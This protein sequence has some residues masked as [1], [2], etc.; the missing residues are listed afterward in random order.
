[1]L[2][3]P[4]L[5]RKCS[6]AFQRLHF[7]PSYNH[8]RFYMD[9]SVVL[10][11]NLTLSTFQHSTF[12]NLWISLEYRASEEGGETHLWLLCSRHDRLSSDRSCS[13]TERSASPHWGTTRLCMFVRWLRNQWRHLRAPGR[14]RNERG[15]TSEAKVKYSRIACCSLRRN[16]WEDSLIGLSFQRLRLVAPHYPRRP[17]Q[18][19]I[20]VRKTRE[21]WP[22]NIS[23]I[24]LRWIF[25]KNSRSCTY[26]GH[27]W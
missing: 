6:C 23:R 27:Q 16:S 15:M 5:L 21:L 26:Y 11:A 20:I 17:Y 7:L 2:S 25:P 1:M 12:W 8:G 13:R 18:I 4:N 19:R 3:T 9:G 22:K 24:L 10:I 14:D